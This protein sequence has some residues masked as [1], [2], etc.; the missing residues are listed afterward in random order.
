MCWSGGQ[1]SPGG[2]V[3]TELS[4]ASKYSSA[5]FL[6]MELLAQTGQWTPLIVNVSGLPCMLFCLSYSRNHFAEINVILI[7]RTEECSGYI[8]TRHAIVEEQ[9]YVGRTNM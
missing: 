5:N 3:V 7:C 1:R 2:R 9:K 4:R 6:V 8:Y